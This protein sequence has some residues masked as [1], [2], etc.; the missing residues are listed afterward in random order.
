MNTPQNYKNYRWIVCPIEVDPYINQ[1]HIALRSLTNGRDEHKIISGREITKIYHEVQGYG[2]YT[3]LLQVGNDE[4]A[5]YL[6]GQLKKEKEDDICY[7]FERNKSGTLKTVLKDNAFSSLK[8]GTF[9]EF[10]EIHGEVEVIYRYNIYN[11]VPVSEHI[12]VHGEIC[13]LCV[14]AFLGGKDSIIWPPDES[15]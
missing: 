9:S 6:G 7:I 12:R 2:I 5:L 11:E 14:Q 13:G 1:K 4:R 15:D 10:S 3:H 8:D